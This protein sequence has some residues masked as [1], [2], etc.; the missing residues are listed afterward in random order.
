[1]KIMKGSTLKE[2][3]FVTGRTIFKKD[4]L[5]YINLFELTSVYNTYKRGFLCETNTRNITIN[6]GIWIC[7]TKSIELLAYYT[8]LENKEK[9]FLNFEKMK[10]TTISYDEYQKLLFEKNNNIKFLEQVRVNKKVNGTVRSWNYVYMAL[11]N[12]DEILTT[13]ENKKEL[14]E[15][16]KR[17][18]ITERERKIIEE[19]VKDEDKEQLILNMMF[20]SNFFEIMSVEDLKNE[21]YLV[22][23]YMLKKQNVEK[24][25]QKVREHRNLELMFDFMKFVNSNDHR[26][27]C[28]FEKMDLIKVLEN[29]NEDNVYFLKNYFMGLMNNVNIKTYENK[30]DLFN[31]GLEK[32][33]KL[34]S[35]KYKEQLALNFQKTTIIKNFVEGMKRN[36]ILRKIKLMNV[37]SEKRK[38]TREANEK[39]KRLIGGT[40]KETNGL[41][42][43]KEK[44]KEEALKAIKNTQYIKNY[45]SRENRYINILKKDKTKSIIEKAL[46]NSWIKVAKSKEEVSK[47]GSNASCCLNENGALKGLVDII[48]NN[49]QLI[50]LYGEINNKNFQILA[51]LKAETEPYR[52]TIILDNIEANKELET[53]EYHEIIKEIKA[54]RGYGLHVGAIRTDVKHIKEELNKVMKNKPNKIKERKNMGILDETYYFH[55][56]KN[57]IE[58]KKA[59]RAKIPKNLIVRPA[60]DS[61][62]I[63]L[64]QIEKETYG[65]YDKENTYIKE[66]L[67]GNEKINVISDNDRNIYG[68]SIVRKIETVLDL[69]EHIENTNLVSKIE[70]LSRNLEEVKEWVDKEKCEYTYI[71]DFNVI[72]ELRKSRIIYDLAKLTIDSIKEYG[73]NEVYY[74]SN[75][76][77]KNM[78]HFL[79]RKGLTPIDINNKKELKKDNE[80]KKVV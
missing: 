35:Y 17:E 37:A 15:L 48:H 29:L 74:H 62:L 66:Y 26:G 4:K 22:F 59:S 63:Q 11:R 7:S 39:M 31:A 51:Y 75:E 1:M 30:Y 2:L 27:Y 80:I 77:S 73:K 65:D 34:E 68:Y 56:Y 5:R 78:E 46:E 33:M 16:F 41:K 9:E 71:E 76:N 60:T 32:F 25:Q 61:D 64:S 13:A 57:Y 49:N 10:I 67:K 23:I 58:E 52:R 12:N 21:M 69:A 45:D 42:N 24:P 50:C 36:D 18:K 70:V 72:K 8:K 54:I 47:A 53:E 19:I 20:F 28:M 79:L 40:I 3:R 44:T 14:S 43:I 38:A 55:D 6:D